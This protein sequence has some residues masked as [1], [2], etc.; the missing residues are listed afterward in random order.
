MKKHSSSFK[1]QIALLGKQQEVQV[2]YSL[3]GEEHILNSEDINSATP[4]YEASLLKS[5]MKQLELD[6]NVNIPIGTEI[7][8][9][10]GLLV[11]EEY[12]YLDYGKYIVYSSEKQEDTGSYIITCYDKLLYSMKDYEKMDITY[13][14]SVRNYINAICKHIGLTFANSNGI[15]AN[16]NKNIPTELYLDSEGNSLDYTFRDVLDEL[17][18][19]TAS[20]ICINADDELEIRYIN[21][22]NDTIDEEYLKDV[23]VTFGEKYG[24]IN[25]VV[26]SRSGESD[27]VYL[28][29]E[30]SVKEDG[31]CEIKIVDNQIMNFNDRSD[32]LIDILAKL[33]G[34]EYYLNDFS[35]TGIM[36]Y[37]LLDRYTVKIGDNDYSCIMLNDECDIT[38]GL[39]ELIYTDEPETSETD[40]T[41]AD[42]TDR[43]INQTYIIVDKQNQQIES[44]V[45]QTTEQNEKINKVVQTVDELNSKISDI[46][47]ITTSKDSNSG[48]VSFESINQSEP[49]R[50]EVHPIVENISYLYPHSGLYPSDTL[51]PKNRKIR[52]TNTTNDTY[53]DYELPTDLL[54]YDGDNYDEFILDYDSQT[55]I[56]NKKVGYNADGT[57]YILENPSTIE[58][59]YPTIALE[60]GD[61]TITLLGY[62]TAY[63]FARLM[64]QNIYTTQFATKAEVNSEINQ[65]SQEINLSVDKKLSN[66]STTSEMNSAISITAEGINSEVSKKVNETEVVSTIN[67]SA[68]EVSI[69]GNRFVVESDNFKLT[70]NGTMTCTNATITGGYLKIGDEGETSGQITLYYNK[71]SS[72]KNLISS[73]GQALY[74]KN[75]KLCYPVHV[76]NADD[77]SYGGIGYYF[78]DTSGNTTRIYPDEIITPKLYQTSLESKKKNFEKLENGLDVIKNAEIY[79]Y[80]F[81]S[82]KD[83]NK[84]HIGFVIA[85]EGGNYKTPTE[86]IAQNGE[87]IDTYSMTSILWKAVQELT[88]RVEY[89]E[90]KLKEE[91]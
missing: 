75:K 52:F 28:Q 22:T 36:Y 25:S 19:V 45:S 84:K 55:C 83:T 70:K 85:D 42:K 89:L 53:V 80:N 3:E 30:T 15:F 23:N 87:G 8:F 67:Q 90:N 21:N 35:S 54:Y 77:S 16:Y 5:V 56:V 34:I 58:Y 49:I 79:K 88:E 26:L 39:E 1:E 4:S 74:F 47:D 57:T 20:V 44:V 17:A 81:K 50:I 9:K 60:D 43:K 29:D 14:I 65:T 73:W 6:S 64:A 61:Y 48:T 86:V 32:Y 46:A 76:S 33:K 27:N 40:Y 2:I 51:Y 41:K 11:D 38:Q 10:Y 31:L 59:E 91:K 62:N 37:D 72:T 12:E 69:K 66:Y 7:Q 63:L 82:E 78:S 71:D 18:Q 13:P 68:E 24:K